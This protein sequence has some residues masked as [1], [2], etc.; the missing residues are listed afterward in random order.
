M[1]KRYSYYSNV[2]N[3]ATFIVEISHMF[4]VIF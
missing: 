2:G 3:P 4:A 1:I